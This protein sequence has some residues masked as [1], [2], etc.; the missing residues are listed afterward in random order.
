MTTSAERGFTII[1]VMLFLAVTGAL[2]AA[3]MIGVGTGVTQQRY[4]DSVRSF[5]AL[6][7]NQYAAVINTENQN[8]T[9]QQCDPST[10]AIQS[11]ARGNWGASDCVILGR[12]IVV[13]SDN[14]VEVSSVTAPDMTDNDAARSSNDID[15]FASYF[16]PQ[17]AT[18]DL[19]T[20]D[21][22]WESKLMKPDPGTGGMTPVSTEVILILRSP[23]TGLI[24]TFVT[25]NWG[26]A[27]LV[28]VIVPS[29]TTN[30]LKLCI[31]NDSTGLLPIQMIT[32]DPTIAGADAVK[33]DGGQGTECQS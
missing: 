29:N 11:G 10:G 23:N 2:F 13:R 8:I 32:I 9:T 24:R 20:V 1:E 15:V 16:K 26:S 6:V 18:F 21:I 22:D 33:L 12:A 30:P 14:K 28:D 5:K 25:D 3:L 31:T 4:L 17:L 7:Q 19:E 27:N